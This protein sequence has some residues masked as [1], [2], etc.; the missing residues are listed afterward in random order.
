M[1]ISRMQQPR[2]LY[3]LGSFVK[4]ITKPIKKVVKSPIGKAAL[5]GAAIYF[6]GGGGNP[7]TA[8]GRSQFGSNV[9]GKFLKDSIL[10]GF[11][12]IKGGASSIREGGLL[13]LLRKAKTGFG[14]LSFGQQAL[15]GLGA[16]GV[17]APFFMGGQEDEEIVEDPFSVTPS[18]ISDIVAQA[19]RRDPSLRFLPPTASAQPGFFTAA[20]GGTPREMFAKGSSKG[21]G[22][23][24]LANLI[25]LLNPLDPSKSTLRKVGESASYVLPYLFKDGGTPR[26]MFSSG[27]GRMRETYRMLEKAIADND[28][29]AIILLQSILRNEFGQNLAKGGIADLPKVRMLEGGMPEID[30]RESG[31]F[32]P[33]GKKEKADDVP[34]MLSKNEF[35]MTADAVRGMGDG[36]VEKG[37]QRMYDQMK[38]LE[39]RVV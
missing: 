12:P 19:R 26:E 21:G 31:G 10:G 22:I 27:S 17:A 1:T 28:M 37:A 38:Q 16:A 5:T 7:F 35:V 33:V 15:L 24:S 20:E 3:G 18:S 4:K 11:Q 34:A 8:A 36:N 23:F 32:V 25:K 14:N 39:N 2:Q 13:G 30:Y 6:G 9:F 29:D